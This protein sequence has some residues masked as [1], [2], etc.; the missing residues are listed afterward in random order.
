M[1]A[2]KETSCCGMGEVS[3]I[4]GRSP[5]ETLRL[6]YK[7]SL[8]NKPF[9]AFIVFT[10]ITMDMN[11]QNLRN[12]IKQNDLGEVIESNSRLNSNSGNRIKAYIW[13]PH[14]TRYGQW[15]RINK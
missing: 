3:G 13:S 8:A 11:G 2:L 14:W 5:E 12:L 10:D 1:I 7:D 4:S 15:Y 9:Y 6:V